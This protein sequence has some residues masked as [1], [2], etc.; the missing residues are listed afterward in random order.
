MEEMNTEEH[1][2]V[3]SSSPEGQAGV[4]H[5]INGRSLYLE[6]T[7]LLLGIDLS[8]MLEDHESVA[9]PLNFSLYLG[10]KTNFPMGM[11]HF[12]LGNK[13]YL[14]GG[15][16]L[17][18][19]GKY[20]GGSNK[21]FEFVP[22]HSCPEESIKECDMPLLRAPK[23]SLLV[24]EVRNLI[25]V[26]HAM[27]YKHGVVP[28]KPMFEVYDRNDMEWRKLADPPG[29]VFGHY[30]VGE[31]LFIIG[32]EG[33]FYYNFL[34]KKWTRADE[35]RSSFQYSPIELPKRAICL[36]DFQFGKDFHVM[37][38]VQQRGSPQD[39][40]AIY[41]LVLNK[42]GLLVCCQELGQIFS[43][44][45]IGLVKHFFFDLGWEVGDNKRMC[46]VLTG[47]GYDVQSSFIAC[48][49]IFNLR[50]LDNV[51]LDNLPYPSDGFFT[52]FPGNTLFEVTVI[53]ERICSLG[54][55]IDK[56][57]IGDAFLF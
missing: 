27:P 7:G 28:P 12:K 40:V 26:I 8:R 2:E 49:S 15:A 54:N 53:R 13:L 16:I 43:G 36:R 56:P 46:A 47:Y 57:C 55:Q 31:T 48:V 19:E 5:G 10:E 22:N 24:A 33:L 41:A 23:C 39:E 52:E 45:K 14:L 35:A 1:E 3:E 30:V 4:L 37:I 17:D 18:E 44:V 34:S 42:N 9:A 38:N 32:T 6:F 50:K 25:C 11:K 29:I 21:V 51:A 20:I